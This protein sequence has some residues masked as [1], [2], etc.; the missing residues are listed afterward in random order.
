MHLIDRTRRQGDVS[1]L[2]FSKNPPVETPCV[3]QC[4]RNRALVGVN[5]DHRTRSNRTVGD[6][7]DRNSWAALALGAL[8]GAALVGLCGALAACG[9]SQLTA[10][11]QGGIF[12]GG[13]EAKTA[14]EESAGQNVLADASQTGASGGDNLTVGSIGCP[15]FDVASGDRSITFHA[16]GLDGDSL[17]VMHRGEITKTAREC[18]SSS[19][20]LAVKYGFSGRVLLGPKGK[21]GSITLPAKVTVVDGAKGTLKTENVRV[22]VNVPAG[23]TAGYFSEVREIDLP[24]Q[25]GVSPKSYR[26]YIGFDRASSG[27]S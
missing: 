3:S 12:G 17:S 1:T 9:V 6:K 23:A 13:E 14:P 5:C 20:G 8:R 26:I 21:A 10:P 15:S 19:N 25:P 7:V 27:A 11:F 18:G 22:V 16:P 2:Q 24:I 4:V